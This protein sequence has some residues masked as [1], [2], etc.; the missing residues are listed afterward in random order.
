M[1]G[2][3]MP[4]LPE[5]AIAFHGAASAGGMATTM[6]PLYTANEV[7]HQLEAS[8]AKL[9]V[10]VGPFLE[11]AT[12]A[13]EQAGIGDEVYVVG[14]AEGAQAFTELLGDPAEA[15]E[16]EIDPAD[17][18]A[19]L[20]YSSGTTGL[21]KG[22]MLTHRN[23]VANLNQTLAAQRLDDGD[24]LVGVLPFFHIYGH[25]GDHEPRPAPG[26]DHG[27]DAAVRPRPVPRPDRG[28]RGHARL[29]GA[30][31]RARAREASGGRRARRLLAH[32]D[33][34][35]GGAARRGALRGG[36]E[37]HRR[38]H[39]PGLR[40]DRDLAGHPLHLRRARGQGRARSARRCRTPSAGSST[41]SQAR[42]SPPTAAASSGSAGRR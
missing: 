14:E 12:A 3:Y 7:A 6:N 9:L 10:T 42:T 16:V 36:R 39:D 1:I 32:D 29:R 26:R 13:A 25:A 5:Y 33:H 28:A 8:G 17:D 21:P 23:L 20:P 38:D 34:V 19:V 41:R 22:V 15:P 27:D 40:P 31:D 18:L 24:V 2:V 35:R 4:N 11:A 37:A 30:A